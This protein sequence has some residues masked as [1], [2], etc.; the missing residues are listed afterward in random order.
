M[1]ENK[2]FSLC[3]S[4]AMIFIL[5][6]VQLFA[7]E[8]SS[9][10]LSPKVFAGPFFSIGSGYYDLGDFNDLLERNGYDDF[11]SYPFSIGGGLQ[12]LAER[13]VIGG[14][15]NWLRWEDGESSKGLTA[16]SGF[17]ALFN[18][19]LNV[20][21]PG[22][23]ELYPLFGIGGGNMKFEINESDGY[24]FEE[25]LAE[26]DSIFRPL[27][28]KKSSFLLSVGVG[29]N[30][31]VKR[32]LREGHHILGIR[33]GY[34]FDLMSDNWELDKSEINGDPN[35]R[36]TGAYFLFTIGS[37]GPVEDPDEE[38]DEKVK[39]QEIQALIR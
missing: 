2:S 7:Q 11:E 22:V 37:A 21:R 15:L 16:L 14:E 9:E 12:I 35:A 3:K 19:G 39:K 5:A 30:F 4:V 36:L 8:D 25:I 31:V 26:P 6:V 24:R 29:T 23:I 27:K 38:N 10:S 33:A 28:F 17:S 32:R 18:F 1:K 34:R 13:A 20:F